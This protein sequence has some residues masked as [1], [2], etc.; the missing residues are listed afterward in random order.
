[1]R[2]GKARCC[3]AL[4]AWAAPGTQV[5]CPECGKLVRTGPIR[6]VPDIGKPVAQNSG[7]TAKEWR[8]R[9]E[10]KESAGNAGR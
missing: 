10:Q 4:I 2:C 9:V 6:E 5:K 8:K 3:G 1:M 7:I